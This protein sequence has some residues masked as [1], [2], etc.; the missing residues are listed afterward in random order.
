M[1]LRTNAG[2]VPNTCKS[3][4]VWLV[5]ILIRL[6]GERA[7]NE[8]ATCPEER[9]N[10]PKGMLIPHNVPIV[11]ELGRKWRHALGG[12]CFPSA[13]W[14]GNGTPRLRRVR[15]LRGWSLAMALKHGPYTYG[16]QQ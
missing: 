9:D 3:N 2:G 13:S 15:D 12:A 8:L 14:S 7:S 16:W 11:R 10:M 6:S 1:W 5:V 4:G